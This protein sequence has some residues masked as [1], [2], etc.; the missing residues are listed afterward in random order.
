[1]FRETTNFAQNK[2]KPLNMKN[3]LIFYEF[4]GFEVHWNW[5]SKKQMVEPDLTNIVDREALRQNSL[6][7]GNKRLVERRQKNCGQKARWAIE[8]GKLTQEGGWSILK[9]KD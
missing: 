2:K 6:I 7:V 1:M 8:K 9:K 5:N 3:F 4:N